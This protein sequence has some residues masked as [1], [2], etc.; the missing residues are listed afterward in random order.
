MSGLGMPLLIRAY[1][2]SDLRAAAGVHYRSVHAAYKDHGWEI[3]EPRVL[4]AFAERQ[5]TKWTEIWLAV[6][7]P[8]VTGI[9]CFVGSFIDQ[10]FVDPLWQGQGV[11]KALVGKARDAFPEGFVLDVFQFNTPALRF[12]E[13]LGLRIVQE[14]PSESENRSKYRLAWTP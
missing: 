14:I 12:Y 6:N 2:R 11:G 9:I 5:E 1:D 7:G 8:E 10:L 3:D 13:R 4:A